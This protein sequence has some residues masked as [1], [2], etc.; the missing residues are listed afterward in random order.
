MISALTVGTVCYLR[1]VVLHSDHQGA[2]QIHQNP[3]NPV[4][5]RAQ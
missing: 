3:K 2:A 1:S 5:L 4:C